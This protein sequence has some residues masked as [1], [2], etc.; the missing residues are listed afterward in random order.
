MKEHY[1]T[2]SP[3]EQRES[4]GRMLG[5]VQPEATPREPPQM[6]LRPRQVVLRVPYT[7]PAPQ[8]GGEL[9]EQYSPGPQ[10]VS[11]RQF[12]RGKQIV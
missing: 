8:P 7:V 9:G 6:V 2:V 5:L 4:I 1:S 12:P 3:V 10:S 11:T